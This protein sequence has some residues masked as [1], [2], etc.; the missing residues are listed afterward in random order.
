MLNIFNQT[1]INVKHQ[2][3]ASSFCVFHPDI[4]RVFL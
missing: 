1:S 2:A 3:E 4:L